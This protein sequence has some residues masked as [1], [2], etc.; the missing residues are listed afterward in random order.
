MLLLRIIWVVAVVVTSPSAELASN[1]REVVFALLLPSSCPLPME[2][3]RWWRRR[4][5]HQI[6]AF[7]ENH[8]IFQGKKFCFCVFYLHNAFSIRNTH[9]HKNQ[10]K[11][12]TRFKKTRKKT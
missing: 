10:N 7:L 1:A 2:P 6:V 8:H 12:K 3:K 5:P 11:K 9:T 4:S